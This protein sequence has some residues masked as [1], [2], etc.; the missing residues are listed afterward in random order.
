MNSRPGYEKYLDKFVDA[1]DWES[2]IVTRDQVGDIVGNSVVIHMPRSSDYDG[3]Y[4]FHPAKLV[5]QRNWYYTISFTKEF[6]FNLRKN[7]K[8]KWNKFD[9][10]AERTIDH[11]QLKKQFE[12]QQKIDK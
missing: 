12:R 11:E 4:F 10:I 3:W 8:G 2:I 5:R 6:K 9:V 1:G 7:G